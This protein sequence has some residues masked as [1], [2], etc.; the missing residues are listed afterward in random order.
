[1]GG[2]NSTLQAAWY[3]S[4]IAHWGRLCYVPYVILWCLWI[5]S[6]YIH[7]FVDTQLNKVHGRPFARVL[8]LLLMK[9]I[10]RWLP[11]VLPASKTRFYKDDVVDNHSAYGYYITRIDG[12]V[13]CIVKRYSSCR[14][15][16]RQLIDVTVVRR[17][18][19]R[20]ERSCDCVSP[21]TYV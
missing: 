7:M 15:N 19:Q 10:G 17:V 13:T 1:M 14:Y 12:G 16:E 9:D 2:W 6:K 3:V 20:A 4:R 11:W 8:Y 21:R 5:T 18:R